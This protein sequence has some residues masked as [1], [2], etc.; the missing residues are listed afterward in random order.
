MLFMQG[1]HFGLKLTAAAQLLLVFP[2]SVRY[3]KKLLLLKWRHCPPP[4][5]AS[6]PTQHGPH[7]TS[8]DSTPKDSQQ[9]GCMV[10]CVHPPWRGMKKALGTRCWF[11]Q[12]E[13]VPAHDH[14]TENK[15][16]CA[17]LA[18]TRPP[19]M[20]EAPCQQSPSTHDPRRQCSEGLEE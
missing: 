8:A 11:D 5:T 16:A 3:Q 13:L 9:K 15:P 6:H 14:D 10:V 20:H 4:P 17:A 12:S 7:T 1:C 19:G 2:A 18:R